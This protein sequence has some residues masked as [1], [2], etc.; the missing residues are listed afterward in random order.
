MT[1]A[2]ALISLAVAI[3]GPLAGAAEAKKGKQG[4]SG[5]FV[6]PTEEGGTV[7]FALTRS[8][9]IVNFVLTNATLY[10][11][12]KSLA[13]SPGFEESWAEY[14]KVTTVTHAP[15]QM[16]KISKKHPQG[17]KFE[18]TDQPDPTRAD[19]G[20]LFEGKIEMLRRSPV[21][22]NDSVVLDIF[23]LLGQTRYAIWNGPTA[24]LGQGLGTELCVTKFIDWGAKRPRDRGFLPVSF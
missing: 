16:Q 18:F 17:K 14:K 12:T 5:K 15:M 4:T 13:P 24:M 22:V 10:C 6:G 7:S 21:S 3:A 9:K 2:C 1:L 23:G 8:G 19:Q 11:S 20:G